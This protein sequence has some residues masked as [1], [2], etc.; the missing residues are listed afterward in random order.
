MEKKLFKMHKRRFLQIFNIS[1]IFTFQKHFH[2]IYHRTI[3]GAY[4]SNNCTELSVIYS[5]YLSIVIRQLELLTN[6]RYNL[7]KK[8]VKSERDEFL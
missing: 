3:A 1:R 6:G 8:N 7:G 5:F 2:Y 4:H